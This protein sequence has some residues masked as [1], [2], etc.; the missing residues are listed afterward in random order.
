MTE[1]IERSCVV[2]GL[3]QRS[4]AIGF[5]NSAIMA[6]TLLMTHPDLLASVMLFR[7]QPLFAQDP[8]SSLYDTQV[9][10]IDVTKDPHRSLGEGFELATRLRRSGIRVTQHEL[11]VGHSITLTDQVLAQEWFQALD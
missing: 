1:A 8:A 4:F 10:I 11:L 3:K 5:S 7:P 9:L 6:A 2:H